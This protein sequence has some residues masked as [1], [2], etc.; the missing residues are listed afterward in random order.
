MDV[1]LV[2]ELRSVTVPL[3]TNMRLTSCVFGHAGGGWHFWHEHA[4]H[5]GEQCDGILGRGW[6]HHLWVHLFVLHHPQIHTPQAH[7]V[8]GR[9]CVCACVCMRDG[10]FVRVCAPVQLHFCV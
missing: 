1:L 9:A 8:I 2:L 6:A 3:S 10:V 7:S 4:E 5:D